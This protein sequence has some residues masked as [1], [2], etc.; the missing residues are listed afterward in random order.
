M[1]EEWL[2]SGEEILG[3]WAV[4]LGEPKVNSAKLTGKL[5]VTS[6][7]VHFKSELVLAANAAAMIGNW[8]ERH[9][10]LAKTDSHVAIPFAEIA[11]ARSV[12]KSLFVKALAVKM[13]SGA[14][15]EFMFGAASAE[16]AALAI[17]AKL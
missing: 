15:I 14:E 7:G 1:A 2:S 17:T 11:E 6:Q 12:K 5:F 13:K 10:A 8:W 9:K 4:Y 3:S 16:K